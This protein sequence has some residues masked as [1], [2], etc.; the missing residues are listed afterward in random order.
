M[1]ELWRREPGA[2]A[3][4]AAVAQGALAGGAAYVAVMLVAYERLGSAWAASVI[5]LAELLPGMLLGPLIGAWLDRH[6]RLRAV[7][8]S[9]IVR[10]TALAAMIVAPGA[11]PMFA[12]AAVIGVAG[13]FFRPAAFALLPAAVHEDRRMAAT[14]AWGALHD[15]GLMIGPALA[16]GVLVLGGAPLLLGC[17]ALLFAGSAL[18][19]SR[20]RLVAAPERA[21]SAHSLVDGA[22][23]GLRLVGR[24]RLLR[25]LVAG[26]GVIVLA[27]GMMNVAEVVLA[28]HDLHVGGAGFAAMVAVFGVGAVLG[29]LISARSRTLAQLKRGYIGGLGVLA[30]G[31]LASARAPSVF[32]ALASFFVTGLGSAASM[33]HDR[34][35]LQLLVP[36]R[37]LSRAH[38]LSGTLE[39]WGFAGAAVLGGTL[40]TLLGA[41]GVF[42]AAGLALLVVTAVAAR[43]LLVRGGL[44]RVRRQTRHVAGL[45]T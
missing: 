37:M 21:D 12:L 16:A 14:G 20:V 19:F 32:W 26:T 13:T 23:E 39:A 25:V 31:L 44:N 36:P 28:E 24:D 3:Y 10:A 27:S 7:V 41:R 35:L 42:A 38:A 34:G 30:I 17:T 45:S 40:T 5:L 1:I 11:V 8:A 18:L 6:D 4:F 43:S 22:R 29:S 9:D 2:R 33:T 15:A